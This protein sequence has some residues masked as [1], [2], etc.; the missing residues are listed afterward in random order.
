MIM[1]TVIVMTYACSLSK[2]IQFLSLAST[3]TVNSLTN[4]MSQYRGI[5]TMNKC[6][7]YNL[8]IVCKHKFNWA[9]RCLSIDIIHVS[10]TV[11]QI[12]NILA[13]LFHANHL[14]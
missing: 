12:L 3:V 10:Q 9:N 5:N 8:P 14:F 11:T 13:C 2:Y 6:C 4:L 1:L 7:C